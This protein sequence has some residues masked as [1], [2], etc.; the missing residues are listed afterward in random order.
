MQ[1]QVDPTDQTPENSP[2]PL[3]RLFGSFKNAFLWLLNDPSWPGSVA[4]SW[5]T[6]SSIIICNINPK[7]R[8]SCFWYFGS[9][10]NAISWLLTHNDVVNMQNK[11]FPDFCQLSNVCRV[12]NNHWI[13]FTNAVL[14]FPDTSE[15][16]KVGFYAYWRG[17]YTK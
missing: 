1:Y 4:I 14:P 16:R 3:F 9:F 8:K 11:A 13:S 7:S 10:K 2:K 17:Q 6:L 15:S 5:K 12:D